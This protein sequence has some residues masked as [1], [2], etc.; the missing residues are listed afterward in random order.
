MNVPF[1]EFKS[2]LA[3]V[4]PEIRAAIDEVFASGWY[5][6]G[7]Q[8]EAF[9]R[10]FAEFTGARHCAGVA[11]GTDAIQLA[12]EAAG[13]GE[14][15]EVITVANTCVPT[16]CGIVAAG[17]KLVLV[18]ADPETLTM[19]PEG[20]EEAYTPRTRAIVPVHLYGQACDMDP[21]LDFAKGHGLA[22]VEDCAQAHGAEYKGRKCG[23]LGDAAAFSFYPSKNLGAYGDGGAVVTNNSDID[24]AVRRLRNY[25]QEARYYHTSKGYNSRLDE[26]QAAML[27]VKLRHLDA[28]NEAR[29][30][31]AAWYEE[32][33]G[34][35]HLELPR[36]AVWA[37]H[38]YH[39]YVVRCRDR[40]VLQAH[41][42]EKGIGTLIHYPIPLHL[43]QAFAGLHYPAA[44]FP[45]SEH[46]GA[47]VLSLPLYPELSR[48]AVEY[49]AGH[50]R[51]YF[52]AHEQ[53]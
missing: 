28:W 18:D 21:I 30:E 17:A 4:E 1:A 16:A 47:T 49:V 27:R 25:G 36:E 11:S 9:E 22:V 29:R 5:I 6:L 24:A 13:I 26:F 2:Q 10:E 40:N 45:V 50:V 31:R 44:A 3:S 33:L 34:G 35:L 12:L 43:Q 15:D 20:L 48:E 42:R 52:E 23:T 38:V 19:A 14:G 41:L 51:G 8:G 46:T 7:K 32:L 53:G 37:R 39:L